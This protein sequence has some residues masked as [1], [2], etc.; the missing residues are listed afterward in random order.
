MLVFERKKTLVLFAGIY[1][2]CFVLGM[3]FI[4]TPAVYEYHFRA[5]DRFLNQI[6]YSQTSVIIILFKRF[7]GCAAYLALIFVSSVHVL[8]ACFVFPVVLGFRAYSFGGMTCILIS[9]YKMSGVFILLA[10]YL[11]IHVMCD[12][13]Y[14]FC[15]MI[16]ID[17][18]RKFCWGRADWSNLLFNYVKM[19]VLIL[20]VCLVEALLLLTLFHPVG[21]VI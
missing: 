5:C 12:V 14:L 18:S 16:A 20:V 11:P 10:L 15:G 19:A 21:S 9:V 2:I 7:L 17:N 8:P 6:C 3:I 1:L 4:K 13:I